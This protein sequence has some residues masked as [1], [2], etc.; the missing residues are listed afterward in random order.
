MGSCTF[1]PGRNSIWLP[2]HSIRLPRH[3][4]RLR[5]FTP[6]CRRHL[7][8]GCRRFHPDVLH[9]EICCH[10]ST[11]MYCIRNS[12]AGWE[13]REFQLPRS[14]ISGS[15]DSAYPENF[16]ANFAQYRGVL[17]KLPNMCDRHL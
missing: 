7:T 17:L 15:T 6:G 1:H 11:R 10:H 14:D 12:G 16:A 3:S 9:P 4:I 2:R 8:S 5:H 13:K